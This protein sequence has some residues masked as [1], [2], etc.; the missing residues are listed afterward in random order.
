[1][2]FE[3]GWSTTRLLDACDWAHGV[4]QDRPATMVRRDPEGR[5]CYLLYVAMAERIWR[6]VWHGDW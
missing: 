1:V 4:P 2:V 3:S 5:S 6:D